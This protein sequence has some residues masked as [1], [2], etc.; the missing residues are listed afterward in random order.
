MKT[1]YNKSQL[2]EIVKN[3]TT[4]ADVCRA[5]NV[6]PSTGAQS[7]ITK[8]IYEYNI[9]TSHFLGQ[10][11]GKSGKIT[12]KDA[13]TYCFDG[14]IIHSHTLKKRLIRDGYKEEKCESCGASE[15]L[16]QPIVLE[17]HHVNG[18]HHDNRFEN[19]KIICP[20]C[21]SIFTRNRM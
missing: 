19:L 20:N 4:F 13:L 11:H 6:K 8:I 16:G 9:D 15:W 1:K 3:S 10:G 5:V 14:S 21:H 18:K 7:Y 2:E 12:R 17:L